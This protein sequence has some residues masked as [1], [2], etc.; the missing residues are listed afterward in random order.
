MWR[1]GDREVGLGPALMVETERP[2]LF[3]RGWPPG[4]GGDWVFDTGRL[5]L[6]DTESDR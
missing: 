2:D 5:E 6:V 1:F 4:H 3:G